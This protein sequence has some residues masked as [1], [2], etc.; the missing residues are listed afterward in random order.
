M[1]RG[2]LYNKQAKLKYMARVSGCFCTYYKLL[3]WEI[4]LVM[5][6]NH[7]FFRFPEI[8][9]QERFSSCAY[10]LWTPNKQTN[11]KN[12]V[13]NVCPAL[14]N[15]ETGYSLI[16]SAEENLYFISIC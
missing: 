14:L 5:S 8:H 2:P 6:K 16:L 4:K 7:F 11:I 12:Q 15:A 3:C 9:D 13:K 10:Y 1:M